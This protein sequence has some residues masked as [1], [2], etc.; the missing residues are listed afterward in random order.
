VLIVVTLAFASFGTRVEAQIAAGL[1]W[2]GLLFSAVVSLPRTFLL[3]EEQGTGD[4]LRLLA[5]P[6]A[7]FWGKALFNLAQMLGIACL[8]SVLFIV[9]VGPSPAS[10]ALYV[11]ALLCGSAGLAGAVTFCGALVAQAEHRAA[12]A[13]AVSLPILLPL[14]W[15]GVAS[16]K[17][18]LTGSMM[19]Q[20]IQ[21]MMGLAAYA[22]ITLAAGPYVF[23]AVWKS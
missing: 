2:A 11:G 9:L 20:G 3:E 19:A 18:A 4:L 21:G 10:P 14:I 12:L 1:L 5:R 15:L 8:L 23:A 6:H 22:A 17:V 16:T 7:V 13:G